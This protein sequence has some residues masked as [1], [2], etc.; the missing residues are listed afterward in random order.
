[1]NPV[2]IFTTTNLTGIAVSFIAS[3]LHATATTKFGRPTIENIEKI[4][5]SALKESIKDLKQ[6]KAEAIR[7]AFRYGK[8]SEKITAFQ[9]KGETID[10]GVFVDLFKEQLGSKV[11]AELIVNDFFDNFRRKVAENN[12]IANDILLTNQN[13]LIKLVQS[14]GGEFTEVKA[15]LKE[16]YAKVKK[17]GNPDLATGFLAIPPLPGHFVLPEDSLNKVYSALEKKNVCLIYGNPGSGK[18]VLASRI[19][20][21]KMED[22]QNVFWFRFRSKFITKEEITL[23]LLDFLQNIN[24]SEKEDI[25]SLLPLSP[26]TLFFDDLQN[27]EDDKTKD[28]ISTFVSNA[29]E[30]KC[31]TIILTSR[32]QADFLQPYGISAINITGLH[33]KEAELLLTEKYKLQLDN[34]LRKEIINTLYGSPQFLRFFYEWFELENPTEYEIK[35]YLKHAPREDKQLQNYLMTQLYKALGGA[36]SSLNK[37]LTAAAIFRVPETGEFIKETYKT[38]YGS[39]FAETLFELENKRCLIQRIKTGSNKLYTMHDLLREFYY[40]LQ[41]DK[42]TLHEKSAQLYKERNQKEQNVIN[43]IEGSHHFLKAGQHNES[44]EMLMPVW[45]EY[46]SKGYFWR[47]IKHI[48]DKLEHNKINDEKLL[49][50]VLFARAFVCHK[51]GEWGKAIEFYYKALEGKEKVGDIHGMAQTF[52]NLGMVYQSNGESDKAL[53]CYYKDLEISKKVDDIHG[54]AQTFNNLG[55]VYQSNGESDKAL[56]CYYK[57]LDIYEKTD[58]IHGM[59]QTFNNLGILYQDKGEWDKAIVFYNK[60]LEGKKNVGDFHGMAKTYNNLGVVYRDK[61]E[62]D[63]ALEFCYKSLDI[64]EKVGDIHGMAITYGN[65][66]VVYKSKDEWDKVVEFYYKALECLEKIGDIQ[67]MA[68]TFNN[69]GMVYHDKGEWDRALEFYYKSL[70]GKEKVGDIQGMTQTFNNLGVVYQYKGEW[71]KALE[72]YYKS[73]DIYEKVGDIQGL[74]QTYGNIG[75]VYKLKGEWD[76]ALKFYDKALEGL[77]KIGDIQGMAITYGNLGVVYKSKG[78]WDKAL[79]FYYKSL[80]I[81]EKIGDIQG[82]AITYGNLGVVY[83]SK[84]EWDKAIEFYNKSLEGKK[85]VGDIHG[86]AQTKGNISLLNFKKDKYEEAIDGMVQILFV[87]MKLGAAPEVNIASS[88]LNNFSQKLGKEKFEKLYN[89][90]VTK[91]LTNGV[92]WANRQIVSKEEAEGPLPGPPLTKG[93]E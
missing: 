37:L 93:R 28:F 31:C 67:G 12:A 72:F 71:D 22:N 85:K 78:E 36:E 23:S 76:K 14:L 39:G 35:E 38:L 65:L 56:E 73:L 25:F 46:V 44:A 61:D 18:S 89:K 9:Q 81:Y 15:L 88:A 45:F 54:M 43:N 26:V 11:H 30:Q 16:I 8:I 29:V 53:E 79:E 59:A 60:S 20:L 50:V 49:N 6:E 58:D 48:L 92:V 75:N 62:P 86:M 17:A 24:N 13:I 70:E 41:D 64:Y 21:D 74:A 55:M 83:K 40:H 68:Q 5:N 87:F 77:E 3:A 42:Q 4:F 34:N 7:N 51:T 91:V 82:M 47:E 80:D 52:N 1:M 10:K 66:G 32:E 90:A 27:V 63:K 84:D 19:A 69:L 2:Q 57:S 33:E